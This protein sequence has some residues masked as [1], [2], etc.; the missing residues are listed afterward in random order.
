MPAYLKRT[1]NDHVFYISFRPGYSLDY[2][3]SHCQLVCHIDPNVRKKR[4]LM[5]MN[6]GVVVQNADGSYCAVS[7]EEAKRRL[8]AM[9]PER[10]RLYEPVDVPEE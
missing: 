4:F 6:G 9:E 2:S 1:L 7:P 10:R 5:V 8:A 3:C